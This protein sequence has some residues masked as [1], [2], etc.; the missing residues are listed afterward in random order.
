MAKHYSW[1]GHTRQNKYIATVTT[2]KYYE[3]SMLLFITY[4]L[5]S[6]NYSTN[7]IIKCYTVISDFQKMNAVI[8][9]AQRT[10]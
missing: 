8:A 6:I 2:S 1:G 7:G 5:N 4:K 3:R 9:K 10:T